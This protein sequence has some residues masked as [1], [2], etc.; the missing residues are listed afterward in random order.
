MKKRRPGSIRIS[1]WAAGAE[2]TQYSTAVRVKEYIILAYI[3]VSNTK[4]VK[5]KK[6]SNDI[7]ISKKFYPVEVVGHH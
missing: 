6:R 5:M 7:L 1:K 4:A 2:I 3:R